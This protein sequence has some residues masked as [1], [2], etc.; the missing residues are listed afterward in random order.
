MAPL[1]PAELRAEVARPDV[2]RP[3]ELRAREALEPDPERADVDRLAA[4]EEPLEDVVRRFEVDPD[5]VRREP[6][7]PEL[8]RREPLELERPPF[9]DDEPELLPLGCGMFPPLGTV[10]ADR[11]RGL[12]ISR[13]RNLQTR[14]ALGGRAQS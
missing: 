1:R 4:D 12:L 5:V 3:E 10:A 8:E 13:T 11:P 7:D 2:L 9:P 6:L 14:V